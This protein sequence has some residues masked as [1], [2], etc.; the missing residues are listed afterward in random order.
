MVKPEIK[1]HNLMALILLERPLG[2]PREIIRGSMRGHL[3]V[4]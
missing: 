4:S 1:V 2:V 3:V